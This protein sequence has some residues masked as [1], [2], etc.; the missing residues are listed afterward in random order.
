MLL[1]FRVIT[2]ILVLDESVRSP[3]SYEYVLF[4][5][6]VFWSVIEPF[7]TFPGFWFIGPFS[8]AV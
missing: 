2:N 3:G 5:I 8:I 4:N 6:E 1:I 7:V